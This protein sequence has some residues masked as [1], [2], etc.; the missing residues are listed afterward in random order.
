MRVP[1]ACQAR[2]S[3]VLGAALL[4]SLGCALAVGAEAR[5]V[6]LPLLAIANLVALFVA[7]LRGRD[8]ELP[9]FE[10][11][12]ACVII[13]ALYGSVPVLGYWLGGLRWSSFS[14]QRLFGSPMTPE[15]VGGVWGYYAMLEALANRKHERHKEFKEWVGRFDPEAFD[16][17]EATAAMKQGLP[18]WR[19]VE[20][21][22]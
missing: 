5:P 17:A 22:L 21:L 3:A 9:V 7:V 13:T 8:G 19:E 11:G 14:D 18:N 6:A 20:D 12:S 1:P 10:L 16:P 4:A 15:D 2:A